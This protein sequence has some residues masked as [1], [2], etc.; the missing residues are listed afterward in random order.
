MYDPVTAASL[1]A[2]PGYS[3]HQLGLSVDL[4]CKDVI[5]G[6][7]GVFGDS[8]TMIG[9]LLMLMN[10][11]LFYAIQKIKL[12]LLGRLMSLGII[13]M[14]ELKRLRKFMKMDGL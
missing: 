3:E 4:T 11:V 10:M 13:V 1:V 5:D 12:L 7:Y 9:L 6:V 2:V 8:R 14:L